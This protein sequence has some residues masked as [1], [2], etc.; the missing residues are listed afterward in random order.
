MLGASN[1]LTITNVASAS[2]ALTVMTVVAGIVF[3]AVLAYQRWPYCVFR[4]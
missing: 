2:C 1:D 4:H 3:P